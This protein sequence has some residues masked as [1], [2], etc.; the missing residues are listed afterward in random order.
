MELAENIFGKIW[1]AVSHPAE[2]ISAVVDDI[3]HP[4]KLANMMI[5]TVVDVVKAP[6]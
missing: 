2:T 6:L 3:T 5:D 1:H 4:A